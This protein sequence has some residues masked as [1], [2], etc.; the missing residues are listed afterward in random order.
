[1]KVMI[2]GSLEKAS[3]NTA[4]AGMRLVP[5]IDSVSGSTIFNNLIKES[6][7][8]IKSNFLPVQ[9]LC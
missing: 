5:S 8:K 1:M 3:C 4:S 9:F 7:A 6:N 2:F